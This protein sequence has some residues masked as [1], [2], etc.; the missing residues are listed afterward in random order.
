MAPDGAPIQVACPP[1]PPCRRRGWTPR[2]PFQTLATLS[3]LLLL[4]HFTFWRAAGQY[5]VTQAGINSVL[6][7]AGR[8]PTE[9]W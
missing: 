1:H 3:T 5:G 6:R 2:K 4:S 9:H 7:L 8:V